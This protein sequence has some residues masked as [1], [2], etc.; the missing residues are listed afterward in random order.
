MQAWTLCGGD[1]TPQLSACGGTPGLTPSPRLHSA[2]AAPLHAAASRGPGLPHPE[3]PPPPSVRGLASC[4]PQ[5]PSP[6]PGLTHPVPLSVPRA[7]TSR[8]PSQCP[9]SSILHTHTHPCPPLVSGFLHLAPPRLVPG[10][11][12]LVLPPTQCPVPASRIPQCPSSVARAP[13]SH[14]P[15][16]YPG[17]CILHPPPSVPGLLHPAP[18]SQC[19][20]SRIL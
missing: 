20:G 1:P 2:T 16:Q 7:P 6:V 13:A 3:P 5:Y 19:L 10:V 12:H 11:P 14:T 8:I 18:P 17:S 4:S 9:G 15:F